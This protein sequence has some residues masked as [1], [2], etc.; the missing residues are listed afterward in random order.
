MISSSFIFGETGQFYMTTL[1][2]NQVYHRLTPSLHVISIGSD[3]KIAIREFAH[4]E[5]L[6][7]I[8]AA[9]ETHLLV[10]SIDDTI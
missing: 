6:W 8:A 10:F 1:S 5:F 2:P 7:C 3:Q 9:E 4:S